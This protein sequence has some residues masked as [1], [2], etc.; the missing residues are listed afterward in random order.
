MTTNNCG[1]DKDY[2]LGTI[3]TWNAAVTRSSCKNWTA[4]AGYT[5][6]KGTNLDILRAPNRGPVG[7]LIPG[8]QPFTWESSGGHSML[9]RR[10]RSSCSRRLAGGISGGASYTLARS[11]D[12]ASSLGAGGTVVAQNDKDLES[13]WALSSFDRRHQVSGELSIELPLG[14]NRRWLKNGGL[15]A[16]LVRRMV[17][18]R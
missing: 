4:M 1:V 16:G 15:L 3:Q 9:Q 18:A 8:V 10:Q 2:A 12:N 11:M 13:E 17:G 6:T 7:L 14:P 5:G